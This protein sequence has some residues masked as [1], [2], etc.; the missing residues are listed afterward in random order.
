MQATL[1]ELNTRWDATFNKQQA[2]ALA[3]MYDETA[4]LL[5]PGSAPQT[6]SKAIREFWSNL[7]AQ[8]VVDHKIAIVETGGDDN[9]AFQRGFWSAAAVDA[10]GQRQEF[11]GNLHLLF[12]KQADGS[13][14]THTHIWN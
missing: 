13:W 10:Q 4:T 11:R 7:F 12:R 14:K 9:F 1:N 2:D 8:G 5:P 3:A 6:G